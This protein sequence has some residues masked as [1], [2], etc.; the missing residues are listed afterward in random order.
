MKIGVV[1]PSYVMQSL[2]FDAQRTINMY[3]VTDQMGKEISSLQGTPGLE[4]FSTTSSGNGRKCFASAKGR[5]FVV[6]G[7]HLFEISSTGVSTDRGSLDTSEGNVTIAENATQMAICDGTYIYIFTYA[8]NSLAKIS[9]GLPSAVGVVTSLDSYFITNEL[10]SGR[11]FVSSLSDGTTWDALDFATAES[12]PDE[13]LCVKNWSGQ[14]FLLGSKTYEIWSNSGN[15]SFPFQRIAGAVGD[16]GVLAPHSVLA[17]DNSLIWV[18]QDK[19]G[20]GIVYKTN[21][22]RPQRIS[23]EAIEGIIQDC[24]SPQDISAFSYQK[25]GHLFYII[26]GGGL[27]TSFCFDVSTGLWHERAYLNEDG[28]FECHLAADCMFSA[29]GKHLVC[30]RRSANVY[31]MTEDVYSDYDREIARERIFTHIS[32]E[33]KTLR[34][35]RLEIGVETGVGL[36]SGQG[37]NPLISLQLSKDGAR[38]WSDWQNAEIGAA[39]EYQTRVV[40][41]RL[42]VAHQMTFRIRISDPVKVSITGAYLT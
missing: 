36:Q 18:G 37:S 22:F 23:T 31:S 5:D 25:H 10:S 4:L 40:F 11:F 33:N 16:V 27:D 41:R 20:K 26:T 32:D 7:S 14:L 21:G 35:N 29:T 19:N 24:D 42:G 39:G 15:A 28:I 1:G 12:N 30:D 6:S 9:S 3:P 2:P 34:Y 38:T 17:V 13:L 8:T